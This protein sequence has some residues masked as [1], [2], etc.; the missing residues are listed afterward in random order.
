MSTIYILG[1]YIYM[2]IDMFMYIYAYMY[3]Y[4]YIRIWTTCLSAKRVVSMPIPK[5]AGY[6]CI[7]IYIRICLYVYVYIGLTREDAIHPGI[8]PA[9]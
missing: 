8:N 5:D 2:Y 4:V 1:P 7:H 3:V 6:L 9:G